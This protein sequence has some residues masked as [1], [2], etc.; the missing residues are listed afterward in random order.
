MSIESLHSYQVTSDNVKII[1]RT[2]DHQGKQWLA[3][4]GSG[5]EFV[6]NGKKAQIT[7]EG[8]NIAGSGVN[9][10]R[11]AMD[12]NG[13]RVV[14]ELVTEKM[15][16]YTVYE[17]S[18]NQDV[19]IRITKLSEAAM[20]TVGIASIQVDAEGGIRPTPEQ[21]RK[22]EFIGDSITCGYGIDTDHAES[23]F[24]TSTENASKS[25]AYLTAQQLGAEYSMVSYSGY[26]IISGYTDND[27]KLLT[28]ILPEYYDKVAKSE[29]RFE[30]SINPLSIPWD[31]NRFVPELI[32]INLGTND[33]SY[34]K[35]HPE[36]QANYREQY[37]EFLKQ[38]RGSNKQ[39]KILCV[40]G[41]MG[42]R[43]FP[44]VE[45]AV[46]AYTSETGDHNIATMKFDVQQAS[47]GYGADWHPSYITHVNAADKLTAYIREL[48]DW[49]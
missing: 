29:G 36:R 32:V 38:V 48:M 45:Q 17:N 37:T 26:G 24:T 25:F 15:K 44:L 19:T 3:L 41:I 12:V 6:F 43:L 14:D 2:Y 47:N 7:I 42:D 40:L 20:S 4:S 1:G 46:A 28:H 39:A 49:N 22:I 27:K 13:Q 35:D 10:A 5:V 9:E 34:T 18:E 31:F 21:A 23:P 16:T 8:D 33:D 30:G 11:I